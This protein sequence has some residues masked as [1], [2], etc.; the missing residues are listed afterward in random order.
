MIEG[1]DDT[2]SNDEG[3]EYEIEKLIN[4]RV[5]RNGKD[6]RYL[7]KWKNYGNEHNVWYSAKDLSKA[8]ELI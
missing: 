1:N 8:Q 7:V 5:S 2:T 3:K 6:T 4:K